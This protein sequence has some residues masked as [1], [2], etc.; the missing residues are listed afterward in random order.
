MAR[1]FRPVEG[2]WRNAI[3]LRNGGVHSVGFDKPGVY[4]LAAPDSRWAKLYWPIPEGTELELNLSCPNTAD[5]GIEDRWLKLFANRFTTAVKYGPHVNMDEIRRAYDCGVA[6]VH[7]CNTLPS[8]KGGISGKQL[9]PYALRKVEE[10]AS[11]DLGI[12]IT[13][14]GGI[15]SAECVRE[16]V[17][18]GATSISISTAILTPHRLYAIITSSRGYR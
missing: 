18:A 1:T 5:Y 14:G 2:G 12:E 4:S 15:T 17:D 9:K 6:R 13:G 3:G 8:S 11:L 16:Y 10:A 7:L